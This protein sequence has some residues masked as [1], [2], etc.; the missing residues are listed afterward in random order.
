[1]MMISVFQT[2]LYD[3]AFAFLAG[4]LPTKWL[5]IYIYTEVLEIIFPPLGTHIHIIKD[6][7]ARIGKS[8]LK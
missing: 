6:N 2:L 1:M 4:C 7:L 5:S 3:P 8:W